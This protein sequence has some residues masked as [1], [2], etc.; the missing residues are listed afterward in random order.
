MQKRAAGTCCTI[1][2]LFSQDLKVLAVVGVF[3]TQDAY[4]AQPAMADTNDLIAFAQGANGDRADRGIEPRHISTTG[5]NTDYAF[6]AAHANI[7]VWPR[8]QSTILFLRRHRP[9]LTFQKNSGKEQH[10]GYVCQSYS[11]HR[12]WHPERQGNDQ[13]WRRRHRRGQANGPENHRRIVDDGR[14]RRGSLIRGAR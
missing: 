5:E 3:I 12:P 14:L 4:R 13:A 2:D 6:L 10:Y 9:A 1:D 7:R 8:D 11:V